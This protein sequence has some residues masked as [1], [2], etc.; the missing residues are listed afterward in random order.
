MTEPLFRDPRRWREL[1]E[2]HNRVCSAMDRCNQIASSEL[3]MG[4]TDSWRGYLDLMA[5]LE[6]S[7][8]WLA[9]VALP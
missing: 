1:E 9:K 4:Y 5:E 6:D 7:Y 2:Y 8:E 3:L